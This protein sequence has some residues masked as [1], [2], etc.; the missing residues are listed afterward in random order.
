MRKGLLGAA[1]HLLRRAT[2][3]TCWPNAQR[4]PN[5]IGDLAV[6]I[7]PELI[8]ERHRMTFAPGSNS[9]IKQVVDT[10]FDVKVQDHRAAAQE[11]SAEPQPKPGNTSASI[12]RAPPMVSFGVHDFAIGRFVDSDESH[13]QTHSL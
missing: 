13:L 8:L 9:L 7:A 12:S 3:S 4:W 1:F 2:S 10:F 5:G 6:A 11:L